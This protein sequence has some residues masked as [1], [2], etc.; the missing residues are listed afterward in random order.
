MTL[1]RIALGNDAGSFSIGA[2]EPVGCAV[3]EGELFLDA[4][5]LLLRLG[6][7]REFAA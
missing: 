2:H 3:T 7:P 5:A 1:I 4:E 6:L